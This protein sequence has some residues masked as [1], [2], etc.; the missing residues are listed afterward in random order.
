MDGKCYAEELVSQLGIVHELGRYTLTEQG[1][2]DFA[3]QWDP[4][5]LHIGDGGMWG[6]VIAS[7]VHTI[8]VFQRLA[9][10]VVYM[11]WALVAGH[12]LR[13]TVLACPARPGDVLFGTVV[14][15]EVGPT[16]RGRA[17]VTLDGRLTNQRAETVLTL[18]VDC[19]VLSRVGEAGVCATD[20]N[21]YS[22]QEDRRGA[23]SG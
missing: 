17:R 16:R 2:R 10:S 1:I 18:T 14:V 12:K 23:E 21:S 4:L 3:G 7:G 15:T 13:E 19:Y 11:N 6:G 9:A 8:A 20:G 5:P 22:G